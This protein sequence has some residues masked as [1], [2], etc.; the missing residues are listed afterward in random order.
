MC[1][2]G[3]CANGDIPSS[4]SQAA[5]SAMLSGWLGCTLVMCLNKFPTALAW[6]AV[7]YKRTNCTHRRSIRTASAVRFSRLNKCNAKINICI[8][9]TARCQMAETQ[10]VD[11]IVR[12]ECNIIELVRIATKEC[13]LKKC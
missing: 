9:N 8:V 10:Y 12:V 2:P 13:L 3:V 11:P 7:E 4:Y 5:Y 1:I 6:L